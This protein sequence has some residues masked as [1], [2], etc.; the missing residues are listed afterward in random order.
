MFI[1]ETIAAIDGL[2]LSDVDRRKI[3]VDNALRLMRVPA[4]GPA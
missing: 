1:R 2:D 3:Y 4:K